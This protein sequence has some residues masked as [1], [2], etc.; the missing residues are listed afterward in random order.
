MSLQA[1]FIKKLP[2][3]SLI[4]L[5][6]VLLR[7]MAAIILGDSLDP[8]QQARAQDQVSYNNLAR[9]LLAGNGYS[10][11]QNWYPFTP[12][13]TPTAHWS[14]LYPLFLAFIYYFVG[15]HPLMARLIQVVI[16]GILTSWLVY[17]MGFRLAG[18]KVGQV[19][20]GLCA[21]Y[22][23]FIYYDATLMTEPFFIVGV[24]AS[25]NLALF[26]IEDKE[27]EAGTTTQYSHHFMDPGNNFYWIVLG[28]LLGITTLLRQTILLW[29]PF[30][31]LWMYWIGRKSFKWWQ[32]L[33]M[34]AIIG[35]F[36]LPWTLRNFHVYGAILPLNSNAGYAIY[37]ANHP[38]QGTNFDQDYA[39]PLP[40]DLVDKNLNEAQWNTILTERA[41]Q[42]IL[43]DPKRYLLLTLDRVRIFFNFWFSSESD[44][45]SN[46]M[47]VF[48]YG[49]YL[50]FI[51]YGLV[52]SFKDWRRFSLIYLFGIIYS[53]IHILIWASIRYRL[54]IDAALM[55][56]AALAVVDLAYR[57][58]KSLQNRRNWSV[59]S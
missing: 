52:L 41:V 33:L 8:I 44:L 21:F 40:T 31:L 16:V 26:V 58:S 45:K 59:H 46:L 38:N 19:A 53:T 30:L 39:A 7:I 47:R 36:I 20:A 24:L 13:N 14:F 3:I 23:Y 50:P 28:I 12:A 27:F 11:E 57:L 35:M 22:F 15:Y 4:I 34:L 29:V 55:P 18:K 9:S 2:A 54:P 25:L 42:F 32:P 5:L 49:L 6:A 1:G 17:R 56:L 48:S 51:I 10:F 43:Q 37:S